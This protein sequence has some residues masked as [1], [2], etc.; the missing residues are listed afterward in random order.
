MSRRRN[1]SEDTKAIM[2]RYFLA[3]E[4]CLELKLLKNITWYCE[5]YKIDRRH[6]YAQRADRSKG[7]FETG[8]LCTLIRG[9]NV[10]SSWLLTGTGDM[11][12]S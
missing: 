7:Y 4:R 1:Y 11:F 6:L 2:D 10:S 3:L 8:W 5:S 9:C 12:A